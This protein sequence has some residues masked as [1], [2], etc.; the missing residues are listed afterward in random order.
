MS[1]ERMG[2]DRAASD[3]GSGG[4]ELLNDVLM[5]EPT[6]A[7]LEASVPQVPAIAAA[8]SQPNQQGS[9]VPTSQPG[10]PQAKKKRAKRPAIDLD[11]AIR[12]AATAMKAAQ[13][14]VQ[15]A[16][17]QA[18][19]ERRKKQRLLKKAASLN[20]EDLERIAVLKRCGWTRSD[21]APDRNVASGSTSDAG[22]SASG[23]TTSAASSPAAPVAAAG[24]D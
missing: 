13:K 19:N 17:T 2:S 15:E 18:R 16:K 4:E 1:C 11:A 22:S 23:L 6:G 12:D 3:E 21:D 8:S 9:A 20:A 14:R 7:A 5:E 10:S 24:A